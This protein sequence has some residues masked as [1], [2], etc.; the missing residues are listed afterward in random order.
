MDLKMK[1]R[2]R[3]RR[4]PLRLV[5]FFL[6]CACPL[7]GQAL[8]KRMVTEKDY[9]SWG[10][11]AAEALSPAG[12]WAVYRMVYPTADTL[13]IRHTDTGQS[14][15]VPGAGQGSFASERYFGCLRGKDF[16]LIDTKTLVSRIFPDVQSFRF[17]AGGRHILLHRSIAGKPVLAVTDMLGKEI[18]VVSGV[19]AFEV[20]HAVD[21]ILFTAAMDGEF[22]AGLLRSQDGYKVIPI[23][24]GLQPLKSPAW[25]KGGS[26]VALLQEFTTTDSTTSH[27][28]WYYG[29][30]KKNLLSFDPGTRREFPKGMVVEAGEKLRLSVSDDGQ[31]VFLAVQNKPEAT[32]KERSLVEVWGGSDKWLYPREKR[33]GGWRNTPRLAVWQPAKDDFRLLSSQSLP[34]IA[35]AGDGI[36]AITANP[37]AYEPQYAYDGPVDYYLMDTRNG[38]RQ[39]LLEKQPAGSSN[40]S[41]SPAGKYIAYYKEGHWWTYNPTTQKHANL[42]GSLTVAFA[43]E[44]FDQPA[45]PPVYGLAGWSANDRE[46][47]IYDRYDVWSI[48]PD[49]TKPRRLTDG[50]RQLRVY[51]IAT[52]AGAAGFT[53]NYDGEYALAYDLKK[54]LV[55]K[56][57]GERDGATG[58]SRWDAKTGTQQLVFE[59]NLSGFAAGSEDN[60]VVMYRQQDFDAPAS[61]VVLKDID[62]KVIY[63]SNLH[64]TRFQWGKSELL[65][66]KNSK[67]QDLKSALFYPAGYQPGNKYPMIVYIYEQE[68]DRLHRF[69]APSKYSDIGF[70]IAN[71]TSSGYLV[72]CPDIRYEV[73]NPGISA[74]DCVN[75]ATRN[76][77]NMGMA[78]PERLGLIGHSF[79]GYQTD[80]ILTQTDMFAA[81]VSGAAATD[82]LSFYLTM[83]WNN[84]R[85]DL[86]RF[87]TQQWRMGKSFYED[88]EGYD[89][90]SPIRHAEKIT[91]PLLAWTGKQDLQV[92]WAQSM[93]LYLALRRLGK[94]HLLLLYPGET[95]MLTNRQNQQDLS[96]RIKDWF[97][98]WLKGEPM[99][100]WIGLGL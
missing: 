42:T 52:R 31:R 33:I 18:A 12:K 53:T 19:T 10:S 86:W 22:T 5:L 97:G 20:N 49:G 39:L 78:D 1:H 70:N 91:T 80:F 61:L 16:V 54:G 3:F 63:R 35:L 50:R 40:M 73:G 68:S 11:L 79:G 92:N 57:S 51:R 17:M 90:N 9:G 76:V 36:W 100:G 82:M 72:L 65:W 47:L 96:D 85:G 75:A 14:Q 55:F 94:K 44:D 21:G 62:K 37:Q 98:Y 6:Q 74:A 28:V 59:N 4:I 69:S 43:A 84:S 93:E 15:F 87:E 95:H 2:N 30:S 71:Y 32:P 26:A 8:Q 48:A 23:V 77:I 7:T 81:A 99:G 89:R 67:G 24:E 41:A 25:S 66:Y 46:L 13:F 64:H 27:K 34:W 88:K 60:T 58:F 45:V 56:V 83:G 38:N 29:I